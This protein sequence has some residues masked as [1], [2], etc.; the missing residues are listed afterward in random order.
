M[1]IF[2]FQSADSPLLISIPHDG[3]MLTNEVSESI[4][5]KFLSLPDTD[6]HVAKLYNSFEDLN[7]N[8]I[9]SNY[10]RYVVDL[11]RSP[12]DKSLYTDQYSTNLCPIYSFSGENLYQ[13][14]YK[15]DEN[16]IKNR[17][18]EY[19]R[20]YHEKI[21]NT[22]NQIKDRHGYALLWDAHSIRS[23]VPNLFKGKLPDINIGTNSGKSCPKEIEELIYENAL[24]SNYSV[25]LNERFK[26]GFIT[27]EYGD[28][29]SMFFAVQ[30][31]I[32]QSCYMCE[33]S[34]EFDEI[35]SQ[36]L[37]FL[38]KSM[39]ET[40]KVSAKVFFNEKNEKN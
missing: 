3:R 28:P 18:E 14:N 13:N 20:P 1:Q 22:L 37:S 31:E 32:A 27:R 29:S 11:N 36:K 30:M 2:D 39:L 19:W 40:F 21:R 10:S 8:I 34:I 25:A 7:A 4:K 35:L 5:K 15:I 6:W 26:G 9:K 33:S 17:V 24:N 23:E 12:D 16:E 38:L